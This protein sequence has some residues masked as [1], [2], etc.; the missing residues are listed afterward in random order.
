MATRL[1]MRKTKEILRLHW[2]LGLGKRQI[3]RACNVSPSTV[4]DYIR[5][6]ENAGLSWP[7]PDD[8]DDTTIEALLFPPEPPKGTSLRC[9]PSM[10]EIHR[11]LRKKGVTLQLLWMEYKEKHPEGYQHSQFCELYRR[12]AKTLDLSL[13]QEYRAGEKMFIDFAGKGI[14][15]VE[16]ATGEITKAEVF[17]AVLGASNY[18]YAEAVA[19]QDLPSWISAH[20]GAFEYFGGVTEILIPD[21]LRSGVT[22]ACRYEPDLNPTYRE[23]AE[24][25]GTVVIPARPNKPRDKAKVEA[26]VLL[27]TRWITAALRNHTFFSLAEVNER[28]RELLERLNTRR[29]KKLNT[30]R[31]ELF[32]TIEK[33]SL[34]PLPLTRYQYAE[35]KK[36]TV[37]IDYHIEVDGHFYSVPYQLV[38]KQ[39]EVRLTSTTLAVLSHSRRIVTHQRSYQKGKFTTL[40]EHR[41]KSHQRYLEWTPSRI[42]SWAEKTGT[43]T[44]KLVETIMSTKQHPEQ[45]FRSCMGILSLGK[46]YSTERLEAASK[47]AIAIRACSYKSVKSILQNNLDKVALPDQKEVTIVIEHDNIRGEKYFA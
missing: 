15:I 46:K 13:R 32:E 4:V 18:T 31:K 6:A 7:L 39:V 30:S 12:W 5:R 25:Y 35:W 41:P 16:P 22:K 42:I 26:G 2:G 33:S 28:I 36:A 23:M 20:V 19:S 24:F 29:F 8:I 1:S 44:A 45:G 3:S 11:E 17:V 47:R 43:S 10:E 9:M 14:P 27:V 21:N 34:R 37:N 38:R 40:N